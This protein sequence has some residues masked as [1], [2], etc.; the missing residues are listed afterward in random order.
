MM[1][2]RGPA[3]SPLQGKQVLIAWH[4][5]QEEGPGW[6]PLKCVEKQILEAGAE[7]ITVTSMR[8]LERTL[9]W[10][11]QEGIA[12][13]LLISHYSFPKIHISGLN[14]WI[15]RKIRSDHDGKKLATLVV[16]PNHLGADLDQFCIDANADH[17]VLQAEAEQS[18]INALQVGIRRSKSSICQPKIY[19]HTRRKELKAN[20]QQIATG[21]RHEILEFDKDL[22]GDMTKNLGGVLLIDEALLSTMKDI[23][24][25]AELRVRTET[26]TR[27]TGVVVLLDQ[28]DSDESDDLDSRIQKLLEHKVLDW[29]PGGLTTAEILERCCRARRNRAR[30]MLQDELNAQIANK[31]LET[32][33]GDQKSTDSNFWDFASKTGPAILI[34]D[35]DGQIIRANSHAAHLFGFSESSLASMTMA[36]LHPDDPEM[37]KKRN[38]DFANFLEAK[39][40]HSFYTRFKNKSGVEIDAKITA[41]R[42]SLAPGHSCILSEV[43]S[44]EKER[45]L[46]DVLNSMNSANVDNFDEKI[47]EVLSWIHRVI[48]EVNSM[49][50][51]TEEFEQDDVRTGYSMQYSWSSSETNRMNTWRRCNEEDVSSIVSS[52]IENEHLEGFS[53]DTDRHR[54]KHFRACQQLSR[55]MGAEIEGVHLRQ[56]CIPMMCNKIL[57]GF[58]ALAMSSE[59]STEQEL[60]QFEFKKMTK[61]HWLTQI[62]HILSGAIQ[63]ISLEKE[64]TKLFGVDKASAI[65]GLAEGIC[66]DYRNLLTIIIG[67]ASYLMELNDIPSEAMESLEHIRSAG[68]SGYQLSTRLKE[69]ANPSDREKQSLHE[70]IQ[71]IQSLVEP[72][73]DPNIDI[74]LDLKA[75]ADVV[76]AEPGEVMQVMMN[77]VMNASQAMSEHSIVGS[78][79]VKT[80][81]RNHFIELEI[82]DQ[83]PGIDPS[84]IGQ[85][86][87]PYFTTKD[88][89]DQGTG[90]GLWCVRKIV[91]KNG[92]HVEVQNGDEGATFLVSWPLEREQQADAEGVSDLL[93]E[94][95]GRILVVDDDD[96]VRDTIQ[97]LLESL[98]YEV[99]SAS[100]GADAVKCYQQMGDQLDLVILDHKMPGMS[101]I[102]CLK[103]LHEIDEDVRV[104]MSSGNDINIDEQPDLIVSYL[105]KPYTIQQLS[106]AIG[107][108][109]FDH[110]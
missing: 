6:E 3:F 83:G 60:V 24:E 62:V 93:D 79:D 105:P 100:C 73:I 33:G 109:L 43:T 23:G 49:Q 19:V 39:N 95:E 90:L 102:E 54:E 75:E 65:S 47:T 87:D 96:L 94:G 81:N 88:E 38:N 48:P 12:P 86:F 106:D 110:A 10:Y 46:F 40:S 5:V 32:H 91:M 78:I 14:R 77:L 70:Q 25:S 61:F 89:T 85:I 22:H 17:L 4:P 66:H 29:L 13:D 7:L 35:D 63:R 68:K 72:L 21:Y 58:M 57:I 15:K 97:L 67:R 76:L 80:R 99:E 26:L 71:K 69:Y 42:I 53:L 74:N 59:N 20:L 28:T 37:K 55:I 44:L 104:I 45:T 27:R 18:L 51:Y 56:I 11:K 16:T 41:S 101:G 34:H 84:L 30:C 52:F 1:D 98:G 107:K 8:K 92:G 108:A 50:L 36:E 31:A 82:Q 2:A 9:A 103:R 64:K